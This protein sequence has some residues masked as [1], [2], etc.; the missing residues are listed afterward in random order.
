M[1]KY[2]LKLNIRGQEFSR[3]Y[4][5][6]DLPWSECEERKNPFHNDV[7]ITVGTYPIFTSFF[8]KAGLKV[9][10]DYLLVNFLRKIRLYLSQITP[11]ALRIV[12]AIAEL[13]K[14][15]KLSLDFDV[16][17]YC[18][19]FSLNQDDRRWNLKAKVNSSFLVEA[20]PDSHKYMYDDI[21]IIKGD[22]KPIPKNNLVPKQ[23]GAPGL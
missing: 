4:L 13:N 8:M 5:P 7:F 12:L 2:A 14:C 17:R 16:I 21:V 1:E 20:F 18:Y 22:V 19:S 10:F 3:K 9:P 15:Y 23:F 11:N 6:K